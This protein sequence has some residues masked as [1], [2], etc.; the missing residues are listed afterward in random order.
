M[1][2]LTSGQIVPALLHSI[3]EVSEAEMLTLMVFFVVRAAAAFGANIP[4]GLDLDR[5]QYDLSYT[6]HINASRLDFSLVNLKI[7]MKGGA[8]NNMAPLLYDL[9]FEDITVP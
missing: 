7:Q 6:P 9:F 2:I 5:C 1:A 4:Q 3:L 8:R